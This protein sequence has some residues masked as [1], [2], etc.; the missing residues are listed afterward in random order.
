MLVKIP[1]PN[2][3]Q[4]LFTKVEELE[5]RAQPYTDNLFICHKSFESY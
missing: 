2:E 5:K 3:E 1:E 4:L